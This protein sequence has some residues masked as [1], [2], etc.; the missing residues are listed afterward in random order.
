MLAIALSVTY[1]GAAFCY[2]ASPKTAD[3]SAS[4]PGTLPP[5]A[6]RLSGIVLMGVGLVLSVTRGPVG[7][8]ILVWL[9]MG[10]FSL[11]LL[12]IAAPLV[13][14]FV[15]ATSALALAIAVLAPWM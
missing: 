7:E 5:R 4:V 8:G 6:L 14:R 10:M 15:P 1:V 3:I 13:D 2:V 11:S 9:S 12:V